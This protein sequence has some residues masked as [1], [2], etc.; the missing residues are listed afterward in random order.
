MEPLTRKT[1]LILQFDG[2]EPKERTRVNMTVLIQVEYKNVSDV[3]DAFT[4]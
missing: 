2:E 1:W 3:S 4:G